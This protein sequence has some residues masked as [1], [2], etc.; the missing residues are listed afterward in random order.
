MGRI[1]IGLVLIAAVALLVWRIAF[2]HGAQ[3]LWSNW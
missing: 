3:G 2:H 1:L